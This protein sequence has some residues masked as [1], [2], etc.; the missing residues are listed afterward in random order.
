LRRGVL[1]RR[2]GYPGSYREY[3]Q[4][5]DHSSFH[6]FTFKSTFFRLR[7]WEARPTR[8]QLWTGSK[9]GKE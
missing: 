2:G 4:D 7:R 8:T 5:C 6:F 1:L 3:H 9:R